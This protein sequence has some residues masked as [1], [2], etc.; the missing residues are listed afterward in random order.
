MG[1]FTISLNTLNIIAK[2]KNPINMEIKQ[3]ASL[4]SITNK[5]WNS[6]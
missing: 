6:V 5:F 3:L 2:F 1:A 4:F